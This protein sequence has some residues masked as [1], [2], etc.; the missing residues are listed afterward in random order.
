M[1]FGK[2]TKEIGDIGETIAAKALK[3][4]GYKIISRNFLSDHGEIDIIA[5]NK[6][7]L[8]FAEVKTRKNVEAFF[9]SY[10][11]PAEAVTKKKQQHIIYT[12]KAYLYKHPTKKSIRFDVIEV[13]IGDDVEINHIEDAYGISQ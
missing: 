12:A 9:E 10:G 1:I 2:S 11:R 6:E 4:A 7:F 13:F 3:K 5:E 8:V